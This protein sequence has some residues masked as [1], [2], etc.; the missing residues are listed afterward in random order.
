M[1][2]ATFRGGKVATPSSALP[3]GMGNSSLANFTKYL[4]EEVA[5]ARI[6]VNIVHPHSM[7]TTSGTPTSS[8]TPSLPC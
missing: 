3:Q 7:P 2:R 5:R 4:A 1:A 8:I 6:L